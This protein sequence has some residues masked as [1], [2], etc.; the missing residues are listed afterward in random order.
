MRSGTPGFVGERLASARL[1]RGLTAT[2]LAELVGIH[3]ANIHNYEHNKQS[4][5]PKVLRGLSETLNVPQAF[6]LK[7]VPRL[8]TGR[9]FYRSMSSATKTARA[10]AEQRFQWLKEI[11]AYLSEHVDFPELN[12]PAFT[13]PGDVTAITT[14]QIEDIALEC[15]RIWGLGDGP[16]S[17]IV[18]ALENNGVFVTRTN[19]D[20]EKLDAF[21]Q[22]D[23][24]LESPFVVLN[25]DKASAVRSRFDAAHE[26]GHLVLHRMIGERQIR[27]PRF[28][29][30][31]ERQAH[32]FAGAFLLPEKGFLSEVWTPSI[33]AFRALKS[34]WKAAIGLMIHA[35]PRP[36][37]AIR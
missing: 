31:M 14:E 21:S 32:R 28:F 25:S 33:D 5:S 17:D 23:D 16:I 37:R 12:V 24:A 13:V 3:S 7:E 10:K 35:L 30:L 1:A 36:W 34:H 19:L 2:S 22:W 15:R 26:L 11:V 6:F 9:L 8:S 29:S 27:T 18:M 4:P 20:A